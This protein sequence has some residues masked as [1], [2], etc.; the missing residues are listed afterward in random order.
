M[1]HDVLFRYNSGLIIQAARFH[2]QTPF[3][4]IQAARFPIQAPFKPIKAA[5]FTIQAINA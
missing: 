4:F 3:M 2:I 1:L 5:R